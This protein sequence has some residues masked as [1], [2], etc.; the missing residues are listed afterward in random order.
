MMVDRH[1]GI[2]MRRIRDFGRGIARGERVPVIR[3]S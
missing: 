2:E 1:M 3:M